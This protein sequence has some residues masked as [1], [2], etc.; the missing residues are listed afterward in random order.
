MSRIAEDL[1]LHR[2]FSLSGLP[3][4]TS[5]RGAGGSARRVGS[6]RPQ[7]RPGRRERAAGAVRSGR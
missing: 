6:A 2:E 7:G 5:G 3:T 4:Q 1:G